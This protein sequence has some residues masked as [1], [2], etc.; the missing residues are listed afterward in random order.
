[1]LLLGQGNR[2]LR[3]TGAGRLRALNGGSVRSGFLRVP[4]DS[5]LRRAS[6]G[7]EGSQTKRETRAGPFLTLHLERAAMQ[8]EDAPADCQAQSRAARRMLRAAARPN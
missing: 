3:L 7:S 1:M 5:A 6:I 8:L 2:E 4:C